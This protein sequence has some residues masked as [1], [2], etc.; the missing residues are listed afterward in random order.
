MT[1]KEWKRLKLGAVIRRL[2]EEQ[3]HMVSRDVLGNVYLVYTF[4]ARYQG[5]PTRYITDPENWELVLTASQ[6]A[7]LERQ[8]IKEQEDEQEDDEDEDT[9]E[10]QDEP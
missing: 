9:E 6:Y 8:W 1:H 5:G 2:G 4:G 10:D 3:E 7:K